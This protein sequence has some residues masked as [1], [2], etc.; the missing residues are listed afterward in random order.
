MEQKRVNLKFYLLKSSLESSKS[1]KG[2]IRRGMAAEVNKVPVP[3]EKKKAK[4]DNGKN[5]AKVDADDFPRGNKK[6][7]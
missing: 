3:F 6:R 2:Q 1:H 7:T 4:I 5:A